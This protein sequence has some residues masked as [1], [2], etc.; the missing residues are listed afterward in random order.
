MQYVSW[1]ASFGF[2]PVLAERLGAG[3]VA[4]SILVSL[5]IGVSLG[6]NLAATALVERVKPRDLVSA[7]FVLASLGLGLAAAAGSLP[8][9][10]AAQIAIG[11]AMGI[12]YPI[13]MG[14][15][16]RNVDDADRTIAT[17]LHQAVY[18]VGMFA[19]PALSGLL[20]GWVGLRPMFGITAV[21][22]LL[23]AALVRRALGEA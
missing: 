14:L 23:P 22:W 15:S 17:G 8:L 1:A 6:G 12:A 4:Q 9:V 5:Y 10:Y 16:I 11:V 19:G 7:S 3:D 2:I 20:A 21:L 13:L 18:G